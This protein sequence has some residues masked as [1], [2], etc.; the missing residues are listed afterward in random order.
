MGSQGE[1]ASV[2]SLLRA[3]VITT[4]GHFGDTAVIETARQRFTSFQHNPETL[5]SEL[6]DPVATVVGQWAD[7]KT[8][9]DLH[10]RAQ[11]EESTEAKLRYYY[12][13]A[14]AR[15]A[16]LMD[17][18]VKIALTDQQLPS[19]RVVSFL[20]T[21]AQESDDPER[22]WKLVFASRT[23]LLEKLDDDSKA[24]FLPRIAGASSS[25]SVAKEL[26]TAEESGFSVGARYEADKTV[27]QIEANFDLRG[28]TDTGRGC[29][30]S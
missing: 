12:A 3:L 19:G 28:A 6:R 27:E 22:V 16:M 14:S 15:D 4:L 23:P 11:Q 9:S 10:K 20:E 13:L 7:S 8:Y 26:K 24:K 2:V 17:E 21:A 29:V 1:R 30:G 25:Q 18:T 5:P